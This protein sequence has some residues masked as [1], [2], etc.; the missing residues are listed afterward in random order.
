MRCWASP[1][2]PG[3]EPLASEGSRIRHRQDLREDP[4]EMFEDTLG[5]QWTGATPDRQKPGFPSTP[6]STAGTRSSHLH[7]TQSGR[8]Q[9]KLQRTRKI[10][11]TLAG[12]M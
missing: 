9:Y 8:Y 6:C 7:E 3:Q 11:R 5:T 4:H 1:Q 2:A 10:T 12:P